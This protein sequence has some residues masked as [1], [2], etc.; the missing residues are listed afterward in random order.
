MTLKSYIRGMRIISFLALAALGLIV[1]Y[2]DPENS[3][4]AGI[5][6]FYLVVFFVLSSF[7]NLIL[8]SI[9]RKILGSE[10][11]VENVGLS[12]RQGALL[13]LIG[14]SLLILNSLDMLVWWDALLVVAGVFLVELYFLNKS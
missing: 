6:L 5:G 11:A 12:F 10:A 7:F 9:R 1:F 8:L 2:V 14:I 3:G 13:A 4:L